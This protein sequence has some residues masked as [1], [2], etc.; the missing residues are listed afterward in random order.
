AT[1]RPRPRRRPR[2]PHINSRRRVRGILVLSTVIFSLFAAQL[3]RIQGLDASAVAAQAFDERNRTEV[4][5]A[6]RGQIVDRN[7]VVLAQSIE[8]RTVTVDQTAVPEYTRRID[9]VRT[10]VGVKG[11]AEVLSPLLGINES[12]LRKE[13]TGT[14][15]YRI[16][17]KN[18]SV[19]TWR[20]IQALAIPGIYSERTTQRDYPQSTTAASLVGWVY[21]DGQAGGGIE[22]MYDDVLHGVNGQAKYETS[23]NG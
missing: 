18:I 2:P 3:V 12:K 11:A 13:L 14:A 5:P 17:A 4:L 21:A 7:G 9:G 22:A 6:L 8:R 20:R 10:K 15:R 1:P 19:P 16:I 23:P